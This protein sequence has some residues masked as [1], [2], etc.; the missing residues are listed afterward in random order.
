LSAIA[1]AAAVGGC[2]WDAGV[3]PAQS[4]PW[5]VWSM[6]GEGDADETL[7]VREIRRTDPARRDPLTQR[8]LGEFLELEV[9]KLSGANDDCG[10]TIALPPAPARVTPRAGA[11]FLWLSQADGRGF[12]VGSVPPLSSATSV[13]RLDTATLEWQSLELELPAEHGMPLAD[14]QTVV[15]SPAPG[16]H[17]RSR[18]VSVDSRSF[19][20]STGNERL[21]GGQASHL[22][23]CPT[24]QG[25]LAILQAWDGD[26]P[27]IRFVRMDR[28]ATGFHVSEAVATGYQ[29]A[30]FGVS[31]DAAGARA[32]LRALG[33]EDGEIQVRI[34]DTVSGEVLWVPKPFARGLLVPEGDRVVLSTD[35]SY[36]F[37][38]DVD[39][40]T[41]IAGPQS[42]SGC[43]PRGSYVLC[44]ANNGT[45][46]IDPRL[47]SMTSLEGVGCTWSAEVGDENAIACVSSF[48]KLHVI[49]N[50]ASRELQTVLPNYSRPLPTS[51]DMRL[52]FAHHD[53]LNPSVLVVDLELDQLVN[54]WPLLP[55]DI[56][57]RSGLGTSSD[58]STNERYY[59]SLRDQ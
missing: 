55:C 5:I 42:G 3:D 6:F 44:R 12:E 16:W 43:T 52:R 59:Y 2:S 15:T 39:E 45:T 56:A 32:A 29:F 57:R 22:E 48:G 34:F 28:T 8:E 13:V 41:T 53:L 26:Q 31:C 27:S 11:L 24:M 50:G 1:I 14:G 38:G 40:R 9:T 35:D 49:E 4:H 51:P 17:D 20:N 30:T 21:W 47:G 23:V 46:L 18:S 54:E 33:P 25:T 19:A 7:V 37:L 10:E 58:A 36:V